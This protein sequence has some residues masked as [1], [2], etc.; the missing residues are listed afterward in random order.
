MGTPLS[1]KFRVHDLFSL[2]FM[3][4]L[5]VVAVVCKNAP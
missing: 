3:L 2:T 1:Q 5:Q 4:L